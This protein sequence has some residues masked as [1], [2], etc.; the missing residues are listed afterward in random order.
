MQVSHKYEK[1]IFKNA[2]LEDS[3]SAT[4]RELEEFKRKDVENAKAIKQVLF[5]CLQLSLNFLLHRLVTQGQFMAREYK[6]VQRELQEK[7]TN[8]HMSC[9]SVLTLNDRMMPRLQLKM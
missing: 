2:K 5:S 4:R 6:R 3:F 7:V 8:F 9:T 1:S